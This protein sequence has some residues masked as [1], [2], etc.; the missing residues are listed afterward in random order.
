MKRYFV[1]ACLVLFVVTAPAQ[2]FEFYPG[3]S[4]DPGIPTLQQVVGHTWGEKVTSYSEMRAYIEALAAASPRVQM[5]TFGETWEG[6]RLHYLV[7]ASESNQQ[8][9]EE[10]KAGMQK[11]AHPQNISAVAAKRLLDDLPSVVW[12][13]YAVHGNEISSTDAALLTAYH[14]AA[15]QNDSVADAVLANSV[16]IIDPL[17][18]PDGRDRFINYFRQT[19]GRWPDADQQA[20]EHNEAWP[21]GRTNHYL[22]DMNRDWFALTQPETQARTKAYLEWFPQV[23]VDLHEMGSNATY[24]FPPAAVPYNPEMT[25]AQ[26][27]WF[28]T[29]GRNNARWFDRFGFDYFTREI[30]DSFY[31]GYGEGWPMF[32][33][34]LG[35]TFEQAS[36]RGLI[37]KRDDDTT[38]RYRDAVQHHFISSL[39]TAQTAALNRRALL[40]YFYDYRKSAI[41]EGRNETVKEFIFPPGQD[42]NRTKKLISGLMRQGVEIKVAQRSFSNPRVKDYYSEKVRSKSFPAG[43]YIISLA[44]PAKHLVKTLLARQTEMDRAFV[45]EQIRKHEERRPD[46]IYDITGWALPLLYDVE[47]YR[48]E[49]ASSGQFSPLQDPPARDGKI[50]GGKAKLAYLIPWTGNSAA[51][52]LAELFKQ[53][54]RVFAA[55][56]SF[57]LNGHDFPPGSLIIKV[58]NNPGDL[59]ERLEKVARKSGV[60]IFASNSSWVE[61]GINFG[62]E[63]VHYLKR[64][65]VALIYREPTHPYSVGWTRY[66]LEQ[67]YAYPVTLLNAPQVPFFDLQK[68]NVLILPNS[69]RFYGTYTK[70]F[71]EAFAKKL[72]AWVQNGGTL[73]AFGNAAAWLTEDK[74]GLLATRREYRGG[75]LMKKEAK[76][77]QTKPER[78]A[79]SLAKPDTSF[80]LRE[81]I[82]PEKE[83]P[84]TTPGALM[85]V[86]LDPESWLAFGYDG[87]ANVLVSSRNIFRPL[88][89]DKGRNVGLFEKKSRLLLSGFVWEENHNQLAEKAYL[90]HQRLGRGHVVAFA[91][92]PNFRAFMDGL[93]LLFMNAVF[94]GPG[95]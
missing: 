53:S 83:L 5:V 25:S 77:P 1:F 66:V 27:K 68:Y 81:A 21:G 64:P 12:L 32:Q 38:L 72:K 37:V 3:V 17:Q 60:D 95:R 55:D 88:K 85:R 91:E 35:E 82:Q 47:A 33:G 6:R 50:M 54:V 18:N 70:A 14:L 42:V 10:I 28:Q 93:N 76:K 39:A 41:Q 48:A 9:L 13:A 63:H 31:P 92:D 58:K 56:K 46:E 69:A 59:H 26:K 67:Q 49:T 36:T 80:N 8:R 65:K 19:R 2:D 22:F 45:R 79:A 87:H 84:P 62:S 40:Q 86:K 24:Y 61:A 90:M 73:I 7:V 20:A 44:Q 34:A 16:V 29:L 74:V 89:L 30:F 4:Y 43:T 78:A 23:Y 94:G 57:K 75:K 15:A 71:G 52:A 11:L 51:R